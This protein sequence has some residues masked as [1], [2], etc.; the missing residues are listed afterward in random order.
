MSLFLVYNLKGGT[1]KTSLSSSLARDLNNC[2]YATNDKINSSIVLNTYNLC[3][4]EVSENF[5]K[6]NN[7]VFDA[8]GFMDKRMNLLIERAE[9][10]IIPIECDATSIFSLNEFYIELKNK[11]DNIYFVLNKIE[12]E[13]D[14]KETFN[15]L[16]ND[17]RVEK[18]RIFNLRKSRILKKVLNEGK[19][20]V[21][22]F[23]ENKL[24]K[25]LYKGFF[26]EYIKILNTLK[27]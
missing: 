4:N 19:G 15:F 5:I 12:H 9:K 18:D 23:N 3:I 21:E 10:I 17:L 20:V 7:V 6:N 14:F 13:Q 27:L 25:Y 1:G 11:N 26:Q 22:I 16:T 8:G 24:N 2:Y